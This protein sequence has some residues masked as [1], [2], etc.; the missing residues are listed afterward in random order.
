MQQMVVGRAV[1]CDGASIGTRACPHAGKFD[2]AAA[3]HPVL[4]RRWWPNRPDDRN[5]AVYGILWLYAYATP[6]R[7]V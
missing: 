7:A 2:A 3:H 6:A 1:G 5:A 4:L